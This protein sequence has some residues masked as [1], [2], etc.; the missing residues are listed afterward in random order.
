MLRRDIIMNKY[1]KSKLSKVSLIINIIFA[2]VIVFET[3]FCFVLLNVDTNDRVKENNFN[4]EDV[5][6]TYMYYGFTDDYSETDKYATVQYI[7]KVENKGLCTL[8]DIKNISMTDN[9]EKKSIGAFRDYRD[10]EKESTEYSFP[11]SRYYK[12]GMTEDEI[13]YELKNKYDVIIFSVGHDVHSLTGEW[14]DCRGEQ[15]PYAK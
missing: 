5:K 4:I 14:K 8:Y 10:I 7:I 3:I 6:V 13:Y 11:F 2:L 15:Y 1:N 9:D 12:Q